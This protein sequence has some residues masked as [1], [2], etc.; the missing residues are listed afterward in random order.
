LLL[1]FSP[2]APG[3]IPPRFAPPL[4]FV[5]KGPERPALDMLYPRGNST[6]VTLVV[7]CSFSHRAFQNFSSPTSRRVSLQYG[8]TDRGGAATPPASVRRFILPSFTFVLMELDCPLVQAF[9]Y[10]SPAHP[11]SDGFDFYLSSCEGART[12][13]EMSLW[14]TYCTP[15]F[16]TASRS[17][18][19]VPRQ[20]YG[21]RFF[22]FELT[23]EGSSVFSFTASTTPFPPPTPPPHPIA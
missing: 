22:A 6:R 10:L 13:E 3:S 16:L 8:A 21:I 12:S 19:A 4:G 2:S 5:T 23:G 9:F 18:P 15:R 14:D 17:A 20:P 11:L 7:H 1:P